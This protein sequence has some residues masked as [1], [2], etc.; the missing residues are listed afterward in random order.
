MKVVLVPV[1]S[2]G[3][4][5]PFIGLGRALAARGHDVVVLVNAYF[6][7][8]VEAAGL[9]VVETST[10]AEYTDALQDPDLWHPRRALKLVVKFAVNELTPRLWPK[11]VEEIV[12]GETFLVGASLAYAVRFAQEKFGVPTA[13][14]H[15]QP[16]VIHSIEAMPRYPALTWG[17][18]APRWVRHG[19]VRMIDWVGDGVVAGPMNR[20]RAE[21]GLPPARRYMTEYIHSPELVLAMF[22]DWFAP[23]Q[24][25]W[26]ANTHAVGFPLYDAGAKPSSEAVR[27]FWAEGDPPVVATPG[28]AMRHGAKFFAAVA[29][30]CRRRGLRAALL[31]RF[32]EQ[33]P[34]KLPD[35]VRH[36]DYV[37]LGEVLPKSKLLIHHGG[38]GT[39]S[40][41]LAAGVPHMCVP[42]SHDQI[43]NA[44]RLEDLGVGRTT[45]PS[46]C[47]PDRLE[48]Q[49]GE[50]LDDPRT[51]TACAAAARRVAAEDGLA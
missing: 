21:I 50:L 10:A 24:S 28:S 19:I 46:R 29:E 17:R 36:F 5:L 6:T 20:F 26:P 47:T 9:R 38:V 3:D 4:V 31:T 48:R 35:G 14:M 41:A 32:P 22:P 30:A 43:D 15:L 45:A 7:D 12:P 27:S 33:L 16:I 1:G 8:M 23:P 44:A 49:L 39:L 37:P 13:S 18:R 11:L 34:A 2:A 51:G 40:Q 25:D 42:M